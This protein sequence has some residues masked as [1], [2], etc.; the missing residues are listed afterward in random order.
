MDY[1]GWPDDLNELPLKHMT[2]EHKELLVAKCSRKVKI[3]MPN[4]DG[5]KGIETM[6]YERKEEQPPTE[7]HENLAKA[8]P[9]A[10]EDKNQADAAYYPE[11]DEDEEDDK[12]HMKKI[13]SIADLE[14]PIKCSYEDCP[15]PA[16]VLYVSD[17]DSEKWYTCLDCQVSLL[18]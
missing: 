15:L 6:H 12:W 8:E 17:K 11:A 1:G 4:F 5:D 13:M 2:K 3:D 14:A 16:A 7:D 18:F 9:P 10:D